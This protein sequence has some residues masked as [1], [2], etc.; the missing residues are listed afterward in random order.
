MDQTFVRLLSQG[1]LYITQSSMNMWSSTNGIPTVFILPVEEPHQK[2]SCCRAEARI[3]RD[4]ITRC[5]KNKQHM[6]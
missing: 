5:S 6:L 2:G 3:I 1:A 4:V